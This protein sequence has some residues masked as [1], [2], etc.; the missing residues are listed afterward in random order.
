MSKRAIGPGVAAGALLLAALGTAACSFLTSYDGLTGGR[1]AGTG[2]GA[3]KAEGGCPALPGPPMVNV[4]PFCID[5]TEVTSLDYVQF[6]VAVGAD[7]GGQP[8]ECAW[9]L[10]F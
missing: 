8:P 5:S 1:D 2:D 10:T 4:G 3:P 7:A 9:N 6:L